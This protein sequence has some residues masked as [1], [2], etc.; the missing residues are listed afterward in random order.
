[1]AYAALL[2]E[3]DKFGNGRHL[4]DV[5]GDD[6]TEYM[7]VFDRVSCC[8]IPQAHTSQLINVSEIIYGPVICL[9]KLSIALLFL[10]VFAPRKSTCVALQVL[11]WTNALIYTAGIFV[12]IW[13][14]RP[15]MKI[16]LPLVPGKYVCDHFVTAVGNCAS[17]STLQTARRSVHLEVW[18]WPQSSI[19][20]TCIDLCLDASINLECSSLLLSSI[21]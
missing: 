21:Q 6:F 15:R 5:K 18:E 2:L 12:E 19:Q 10:R 17:P 11:L 1:M 20:L 9:V 3:T 13:Q 14:C 8:K 7:K 4:W 16:W